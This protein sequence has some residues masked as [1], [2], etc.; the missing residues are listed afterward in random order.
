MH[1]NE[2]TVIHSI[3]MIFFFQNGSFALFVRH[4]T[5]VL[6]ATRFWNTSN[7]YKSP[8]LSLSASWKSSRDRFPDFERH[9]SPPWTPRKE[10]KKRFVD[11]EETLRTSGRLARNKHSDVGQISAGNSGR[12]KNKAAS[13][14]LDR[15]R[16]RESAVT[17]VT[18]WY[19]SISE[20]HGPRNKNR[21]YSVYFPY[22]H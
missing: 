22:S 9:Y 3:F 17:G 16:V 15:E 14:D 18:T 5:Y 12:I 21:E 10:R 2:E 13:I 4:S 8:F 1:S 19:T 20:P 11:R 7:D 6:I